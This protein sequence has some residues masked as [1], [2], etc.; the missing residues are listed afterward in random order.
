MKKIYQGSKLFVI[1]LDLSEKIYKQ[2][3]D[4]GYNPFLAIITNEKINIEWLKLCDAVLCLTSNNNYTEIHWAYEHNIPV[5]YNIKDLLN[6][7]IEYK[8]KYTPILW[9]CCIDNGSQKIIDT[10]ITKNIALENCLQEK[11]PTDYKSSV[12]GITMNAYLPI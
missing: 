5:Y 2:L 8:I 6:N 3:I 4:Y 9:E 1:S 11:K 10:G 12:C 7:T